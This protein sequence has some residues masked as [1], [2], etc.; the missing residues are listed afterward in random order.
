[1]DRARP[2]LRPLGIGEMVDGALRLYRTNFLTLIKISG[3]VLV[4]LGLIQLIATVMVGPVDFNAFVDIDPNATAAEQL[5]PLIPLYT[6]LGLTS[7]LTL[8]GTVLVQGASITVFAQVYQGVE[9]DWKASLGTGAKRFVALAVSTFLLSLGSGLGLILCIVPGVFLFTTWSVSP[10]ALVAEQKGPVA[11]LSR[12]YQL[13][14]GRFWPVFGAIVLSYLL[15]SVASQIVSAIA[16]VITIAVSVNTGTFSFVPT[17]VG[18]IIVSVLAAPFLAAM[19]T[20][21]YFDLRVRKEGYDLEL[22]AADLH[23]LDSVTDAAPS[24][25]DD[26]PFGLDSPGRT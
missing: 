10:A 5:A 1:M 13:V 6:A 20:I 24:S 2:D 25:P 16:S 12:S 14:R 22:M 19:I 3:A 21:I 9:P 17:V 15:Y 26:N 8:A 7:L 23:R 4:P 11:A 18:S